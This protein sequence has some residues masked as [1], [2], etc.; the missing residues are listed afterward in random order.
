MIYQLDKM[1]YFEYND[2]RNQQEMCYKT[3]SIKHSKVS[4][5]SYYKQNLCYIT[6]LL[7]LFVDAL[8]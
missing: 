4:F 7:F 6:Q 5:F 3:K 8:L 1:E 2:F